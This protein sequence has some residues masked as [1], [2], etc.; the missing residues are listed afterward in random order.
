MV[1]SK[2]NQEFLE[3]AAK[4]KL[5]LMDC[6]GVLTDGKLHYSKDGEEI[7]TFHVHD[8]Q[9]IVN[10]NLAGFRSGI[11]TGR[12]SGMLKRRAEELGIHY[13]IQKSKD[14]TKDFFGIIRKAGVSREEVAYI[15]DDLP[16]LELLKLVNLPIAVA[17]CVDEIKGSVLY[18]TNKNGGAGAVREVID[19]LLKIKIEKK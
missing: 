10:W 13:L 16:D 2:V 7:K 8:G 11:I 14:K 3:R 18:I 12:E 6:D 9:G 15:G 4:V 5:L 17:N 1:K 19:L